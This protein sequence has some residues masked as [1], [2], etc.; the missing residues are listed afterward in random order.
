[1]TAGRST[2]S[3]WSG[4]RRERRC[5]RSKRDTVTTEPIS[6]KSSSS[7]E[8]SITR[9][10]MACSSVLP[11]PRHP[12]SATYLFDKRA[13]VRHLTYDNGFVFQ[14][15]DS[16]PEPPSFVPPETAGFFTRGI[17]T[18][19]VPSPR[20]RA[21]L[22]PCRSV[23]R[24]FKAKP[25]GCRGFG[26]SCALTLTESNPRPGPRHRADVGV[27]D[28][29]RVVVAGAH[30]GGIECRPADR[31]QRA[32]RRHFD[33]EALK[34]GILPKSARSTQ[35]RPAS[36]HRRLRAPHRPTEP[37]RS[38]IL[39]AELSLAAAP[40]FSRSCPRSSRASTSLDDEASKT[41]MAGT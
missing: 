39:A 26:W 38:E 27:A 16:R 19:L 4:P 33:A 10:S 28:G 37:R 31:H 8:Y 2:K 35:R 11:C 36:C 34:N 23:W 12:H 30:Q 21:L 40:S 24:A 15:A 17:W 18:P 3:K 20:L 32:G 1:M 6:R 9:A 22:K 29:G 5:R 25:R 14:P 41:W 13:N 7:F